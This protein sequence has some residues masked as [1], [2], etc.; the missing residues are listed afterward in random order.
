MAK[1]EIANDWL[2]DI[3]K[4]FGKNAFKTARQIERISVIPTGCLTL[5]LA[6]GVG[7]I[8][9]GKVIEIYGP[10]S[11]G[12]TSLAYGLI[13]E[14]EKLGGRAAVFDYEAASDPQWMSKWGID[15]DSLLVAKPDSAEIGIDMIK[16]T[17][18][19]GAVDLIIL[20][21]LSAFVPSRIVTADAADNHMGVLARLMSEQLPNIT[22]L[23]DEYQTNFVVL[24]QIRSKIGV[25]FGNPITTSGGSAMGFYSSVRIQTGGSIKITDV[26]AKAEDITSSV[27][28]RR[29]TISKNKVA[30]PQK[31]AETR[32]FVEGGYD[33]GYDLLQ[34]GDKLEIITK[35]GHTYFFKEEKL[36]TGK[37]NTI[38]F[39]NGDSELAICF[40]NEI[41]ERLGLPQIVYNTGAKRI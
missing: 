34:I 27:V 13:N 15:V 14:V 3:K 16:A 20:D 24:N 10:F 39:L 5:D 37:E 22:K 11:S 32:V 8:P 17:I 40:E 36:A 6:L 1:N 30:P 23:C 26:E 29:F 35:T 33:R 21:S 38:A 41:R 19:S 9:R 12:K 2:S 25:T 7:G 28:D 4:Q 18:K 31:V